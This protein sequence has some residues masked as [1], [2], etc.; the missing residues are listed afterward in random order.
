[1]GMVMEPQP[2]SPLITKVQIYPRRIPAFTII[3]LCIIA[4]L[5]SYDFGTINMK[6]N[7]R[8]SLLD[9]PEM[10]RSSGFVQFLVFRVA[11]GHKD[12]HFLKAG[13]ISSPAFAITEMSQA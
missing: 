13:K 3:L 12:R 7:D 6:K 5:Y 2:S 9:G 11:Q 10:R 1:M 4:Q 8:I